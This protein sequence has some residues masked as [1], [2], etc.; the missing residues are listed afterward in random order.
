MRKLLRSVARH[1]MKLA[2]IQHMNRKIKL[3]D[4]DKKESYFSRH[5]RDYVGGG[6]V[7]YEVERQWHYHDHPARKTEKVY[8]HTVCGHYGA[9]PLDYPF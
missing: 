8:R 1:N 4:R 7:S 3:G 9:E 5:W 2:G 6:G